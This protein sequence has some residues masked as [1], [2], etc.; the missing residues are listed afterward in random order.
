MKVSAMSSWMLL[1][2][3]KIQSETDSYA[4]GKSLCWGRVSPAG[5]VIIINDLQFLIIQIGKCAEAF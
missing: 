1:F 2:P 3:G 4:H 5:G